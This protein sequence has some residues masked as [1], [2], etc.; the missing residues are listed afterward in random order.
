MQAF[1]ALNRLG[2]DMMIHL[3]P[4]TELRDIG[5]D[6]KRHDD[7]IACPGTRIVHI[8]T[9]ACESRHLPDRSVVYRIEIAIAVQNVLGD[10]NLVEVHAALKSRLRSVEQEIAKLPSR[11]EIGAVE[12]PAQLSAT[13]LNVQTGLAGLH[14]TCAPLDA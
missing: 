5:A 3:F 4:G 7:R 12:N 2:T 9:L 8:Q 1:D 14:R 11:Y 13:L 10:F 6:R